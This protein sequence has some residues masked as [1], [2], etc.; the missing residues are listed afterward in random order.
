M[1]IGQEIVAILEKIMEGRDKFYYARYKT[2]RTPQ[3]EEFLQENNLKIQELIYLWKHE[4]TEIPTCAVCRQ[5]S[6]IAKWT[7][8]KILFYGMF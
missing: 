7:L 5:T 6:G 1:L 2:Y 8:F 4:M 3:L